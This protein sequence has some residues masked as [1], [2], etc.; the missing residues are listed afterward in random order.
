MAT[1]L[2]FAQL[3]TDNATDPGGK[4][5]EATAIEKL[6]N[7]SESLRKIQVEHVKKVSEGEV[8]LFADWHRELAD[9]KP[10]I[11]KLASDY[12]AF[13]ALAN[14]SQQRIEAAVGLRSELAFLGAFLQDA[15]HP[16]NAKVSLTAAQTAET[17]RI[18]AAI[19]RSK[20]ANPDFDTRFAVV[21][22]TDTFSLL[23]LPTPITVTAPA[24][25]TV[26][27]ESIAG[28]V[29]ANGLPVAEVEVGADGLAQVFWIS[30]GEAVANCG[31]RIHC[32]PAPDEIA[33]SIRVV[34]PVPM[35]APV[36]P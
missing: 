12:T 9:R 19:S 13:L 18:L 11:E 5:P 10:R 23:F 25:E 1:T 31:V 28:G 8:V 33:V 22:P 35:P 21:G 30:R 3:P 36:A 2:T 26:Y 6:K 34:Q 14:G 17:K 4:R 20:D 15:S 16:P 29:F 27:F 32:A 7:R 24:G